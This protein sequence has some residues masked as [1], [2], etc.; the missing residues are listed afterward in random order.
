MTP[1]QWLQALHIIGVLTKRTQAVQLPA[2]SGALL[3]FLL[4]PARQAVPTQPIATNVSRTQDLSWTA[5]SGATSRDVYFGTV[6]PPVTKVIADGT[7]LTY[8]TG[9]MATSTTYYW[10]VDE[11]N[12]GGT[13]TAQS[14]ALLL[15]LH[16]QVQLQV[17]LRLTQQQMSA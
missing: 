5:G 16:R 12:A 3:L 11:K 14:G 4:R 10:R 15:F 17:L 6:N 9:T 2:P 7:V 8:D 13:T 1:G